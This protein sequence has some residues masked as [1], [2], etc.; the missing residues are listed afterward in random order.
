VQIIRKVALVVSVRGFQYRVLPG[1][2]IPGVD[3]PFSL[4]NSCCVPVFS[5]GLRECGQM[6]HKLFGSAGA[7]SLRGPIRMMSTDKSDRMTAGRDTATG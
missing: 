7:T 3:L 1:K 5:D 4:D 6:I 2:P